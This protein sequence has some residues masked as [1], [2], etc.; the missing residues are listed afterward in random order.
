[1]SIEVHENH[2]HIVNTENRVYMDEIQGL[3]HSKLEYDKEAYDKNTYPREYRSRKLENFYEK[4]NDIKVGYKGLV[5]NDLPDN[6]SDKHLYG[7]EYEGLP[8]EFSILLSELR[9]NQSVCLHLFYPD[10]VKEICYKQTIYFLD[11]VTSSKFKPK[12]IPNIHVVI[13]MCY[14]MRFGNSKANNK[15]QVLF[16]CRS[17]AHDNDSYREKTNGVCFFI[18]NIPLRNLKISQKRS[19]A[20]LDYATELQVMLFKGYVDQYEF[21]HKLTNFETSF[22]QITIHG[23]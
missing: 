21:N 22:K 8:E 1:M 16:Y 5:S 11:F 7:S 3:V 14:I 12:L 6:G 9:N 13:P 18:E 10:I 15:L 20:V 4:Y 19:K 2:H 17:Y 23:T